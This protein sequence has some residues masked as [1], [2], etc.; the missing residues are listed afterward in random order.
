MSHVF[1]ASCA[2]TYKSEGPR[3]PAQVTGEV[4]LVADVPPIT[5]RVVEQNNGV[6]NNYAMVGIF[7]NEGLARAEDKSLVLKG[8]KLIGEA[9]AD[10][11]AEVSIA[12]GSTIV[13]S[14]GKKSATVSLKV[15]QMKSIKL[16]CTNRFIQ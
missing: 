13:T 8:Y 9:K 15:G 1:L 10:G 7:Q 12:K 11:T 2:S 16:S 3:V 6:S 4:G 14:Q 5:C